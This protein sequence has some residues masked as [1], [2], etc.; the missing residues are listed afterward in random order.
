MK[1]FLEETIPDLA[2]DCY[3][4][5]SMGNVEVGLPEAIVDDFYEWFDDQLDR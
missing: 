4:T 5:N 1:N 3:V 2:Q